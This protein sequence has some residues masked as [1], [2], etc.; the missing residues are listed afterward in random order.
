M[1]INTIDDLL[2]YLSEYTQIIVGD[3]TK[4]T[5]RNIVLEAEQLKLVYKSGEN[6]FYLD[7]LGKQ[8]VDTRLTWSAFQARKKKKNIV[9]IKRLNFV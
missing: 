5:E 7:R 3:Y 1:D 9:L 6:T 8:V 4:E 2:K